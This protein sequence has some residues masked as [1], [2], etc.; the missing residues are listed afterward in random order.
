M[1]SAA[2]W[3][4]FFAGDPNVAGKTMRMNNRPL[5]VIGV[6]PDGFDF[7]ANNQ[8]WI[9]LALDRNHPGKAAAIIPGT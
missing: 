7:G 2:L 3:R 8:V 1:I 5:T 9:P 4:S 6:L